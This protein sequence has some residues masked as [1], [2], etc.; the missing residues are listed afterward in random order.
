M[1]EI[2][3]VEITHFHVNQKKSRTLNSLELNVLQRVRYSMVA[4]T[5]AIHKSENKFG[6]H[7]PKNDIA[8]LNC[9]QY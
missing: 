3:K 6:L 4:L 2:F 7:I 9:N 1:E 5:A 8:K